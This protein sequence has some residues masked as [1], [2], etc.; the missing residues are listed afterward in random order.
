MYYEL[1]QKSVFVLPI[2]IVYTYSVQSH[3]ITELEPLKL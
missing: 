3:K 1:P 2:I